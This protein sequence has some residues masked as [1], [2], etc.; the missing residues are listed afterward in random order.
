VPTISPKDLD[1]ALKSG[2]FAPVYFFH[3]EED[4]R[5]DAAL[6]R[7]VETAVDPAMRDFNCEVRRGAELDAESLESL[8][9]TPPMMAE[10]RLVAVRD[11]GALKK[12]PRRT[13]DRYLQRPAPD[14]VLVLIAAA[15]A[16]PDKALLDAAASLEF[17]PLNGAELG[18]WV[19]RYAKNELGV[20][21]TPAAADLLLGAVGN[22]L[23]QLAAELDKLASYVRGNSGGDAAKDAAAVVD[24][25]AVSAVVGVRRGET[26]GDLLDAVARHDA[27]GAYGLVE[28]VLA[29][30]K[31]SAVTV[32]LALGTQFLALAWGQTMRERGTNPGMLAK[33]YWDLLKEGKGAFPGRPWGEAVSAWVAAVD[34][35]TPASLDRA[36]ELLL[37]ADLTLKE[38]RISSDEQ[39]IGTLVL[40]LCALPGRRPRS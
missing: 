1:T 2:A 32:V 19:A 9:G 34:G 13:L 6:Q 3:G 20:A 24:E 35:W 15:G 22:D 28:H 7:L 33:A 37:E 5:K 14:T 23:Q 8:L 10:R 4:F 26:L 30:P 12:D 11:V 31:A 36:L 16:K 18:K 25:D 38:T 40:A 17:S 21:V 29:Q 27:A 39:V